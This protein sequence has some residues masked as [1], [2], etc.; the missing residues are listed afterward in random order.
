MGHQERKEWPSM[1]S[2]GC[3]GDFP[4]EMIHICVMIYIGKDKQ[5][6]KEGTPYKAE[7][8]GLQKRTE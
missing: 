3:W 7:G 8:I 6:D 2:G 5:G 1:G 4:E